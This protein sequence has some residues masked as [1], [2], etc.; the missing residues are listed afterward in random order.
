MSTRCNVI[1]NSYDKSGEPIHYQLYHHHDGY[2]LGVGADLVEY[3]KEIKTN[4][5]NGLQILSSC[6]KLAD[7]LCDPL[8]NDEYENEGTNICLHGDIEYLYIIDLSTQV[9]KCFEINSWRYIDNISLM[10]AND[11]FPNDLRCVMSIDF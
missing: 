6:E 4:E 10:L 3:I 11:E 5:D 9:L 7:Y 2:P 8:R 1:I